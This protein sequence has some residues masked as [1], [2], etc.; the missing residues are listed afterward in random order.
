LSF[1][2]SLVLLIDHYIL[3]LKEDIIATNYN[4]M[5]KQCWCDLFSI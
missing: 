5:I 4:S 1:E 3:N 2:I